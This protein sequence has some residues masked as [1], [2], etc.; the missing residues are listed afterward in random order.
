[1]NYA[2]LIIH[3]YGVSKLKVVQVR[4]YHRGCELEQLLTEMFCHAVYQ[5]L[6]T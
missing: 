6:I 1:M 4:E 2:E 5:F 3:I